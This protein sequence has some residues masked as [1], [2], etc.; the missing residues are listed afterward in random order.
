MSRSRYK[1]FDIEFEPYYSTCSAVNWLTLFGFK[2]VAEIL[3]DSFRFLI[4]ENRIQLHGYVI[5]ENH[6]HFIASSQNLSKEIG[7]FKSYTAR[8]IIDF[9]TMHGFQGILDQLEFYKKTHKIKQRYQLWQEGSHPQKIMTRAMLNQKLDYIHYN[10]VRKGYVEDPSYWRYS[11]YGDYH[12][13][14]GLLPVEI[15]G[16]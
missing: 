8:T 1:I 4:R 2:E 12:G 9:F 14:H 7:D 16:L 10:P 6:L 13:L 11:S 3:L 15:L 5:M